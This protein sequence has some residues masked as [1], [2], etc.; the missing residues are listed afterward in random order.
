MTGGSQE[1]RNDDRTL[2][3][4]HL[5][6]EL[7]SH[8]GS[9]ISEDGCSLSAC[10]LTS[11]E[12]RCA[13]RPLLFQS[14]SIPTPERHHELVSSIESEPIIGI[15]IKELHINFTRFFPPSLLTRN[16]TPNWLARIPADLSPKIVGL[17]KI[18]LKKFSFDSFNPHDLLG[19]AEFQLLQSIIIDKC[20]FRVEEIATLA[21]AVPC[22]TELRVR[23]FGW[24]SVK[25]IQ[26]NHQLSLQTL[27]FSYPYPEPSINALKWIQT[28]KSLNTLSSLSMV[29]PTMS[30]ARAVCELLQAL[31][32]VIKH[33]DLHFVH[34]ASDFRPRRPDGTSF[35]RR[36]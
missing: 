6:L 2:S 7:I 33:L 11:K 16:S 13:C 22:L 17:R 35:T 28:S 9:F 21:N 5:P 8:I 25:P 31:G 20:C 4:L 1:P 26:E 18:S 27:E 29:V 24:Q 32:P 36:C 14:I 10:T 30:V 19:F 12:W 23:G 3:I 34:G 15:W